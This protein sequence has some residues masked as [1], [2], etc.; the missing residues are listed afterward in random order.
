VAGRKTTALPGS[1]PFPIIFKTSLVAVSTV[2]A[3]IHALEICQVFMKN[4][5]LKRMEHLENSDEET[6][7]KM[8]KGGEKWEVEVIV[9]KWIVR[10]GRCVRG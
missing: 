5:V 7:I 8:D 9:L 1:L 4:F 10:M 2:T 6:R 3:E